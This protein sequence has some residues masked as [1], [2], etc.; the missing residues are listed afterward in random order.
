MKK[1]YFAG[2]VAQGNWRDKLLGDRCMTRGQFQFMS[3][4]AYNGPFGLSCDHGCAHKPG[5]H[6]AARPTV[7]GYSCE[8]FTGGDGRIAKYLP[9]KAAVDRCLYQIKTSDLVIAYI[10]AEAH[11]TLAEIGYASAMGKQILLWVDHELAKDEE[12]GVDEFWFIKRMRGVAFMG[13]GEPE[14]DLLYRLLKVE[15]QAG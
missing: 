12:T 2:K 13:Y 9:R 7:D 3:G 15:T 6:A 4:H 1:V 14:R 8:D 11:G 5:T 10:E